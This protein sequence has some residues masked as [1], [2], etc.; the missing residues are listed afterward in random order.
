MEP[1][2]PIRMLHPKDQIK[3]VTD[4][5]EGD[6]NDKVDRV[7]FMNQILKYGDEQIN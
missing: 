3:S 2:S 7:I 6:L 5:Y 4:T 1:K